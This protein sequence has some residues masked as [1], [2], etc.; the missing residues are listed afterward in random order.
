MPIRL[1]QLEF[2]HNK[3]A[4]GASSSSG[5]DT[6]LCLKVTLRDIDPKLLITSDIQAALPNL[7]RTYPELLQ[8]MSHFR[9]G[10]P[11]SQKEIQE[12]RICVAYYGKGP[13]RAVLRSVI[14][15]ASPIL[16]VSPEVAAYARA[17]LLD[18]SA[19][20]PR[21]LAKSEGHDATV[22]DAKTSGLTSS[23]DFRSSAASSQP[24]GCSSSTDTGFSAASSQP[25]SCSSS[26]IDICSSAASSSSPQ[27]SHSPRYQPVASE[28][29]HN[30]AN[31]ARLQTHA[32]YDKP[33]VTYPL[34]GARR[35]ISQILASIAA[36]AHLLSGSTVPRSVVFQDS[37]GYTRTVGSEFNKNAVTLCKHL[38]NLTPDEREIF[39]F[40]HATDLAECLVWMSYLGQKDFHLDNIMYD[41]KLNRLF[42]IDFD[43]CYTPK[44]D[45][46]NYSLGKNYSQD[47]KTDFKTVSLRDLRSPLNPADRYT[48]N[49]FYRQP[50]VHSAEKSPL[51]SIEKFQQLPGLESLV[52]SETFKQ[53]YYSSL[54]A[55][56]SLEA[57]HI[58]ACTSQIA[59]P[60]LRQQV[61][62]DFSQ[63]SQH[64]REQLCRM[65]EFRD[66]Y[67]RDPTRFEARLRRLET[68]SQITVERWVSSQT[69]K[70]PMWIDVNNIEKLVLDLAEVQQQI[71]TNLKNLWSVRDYQF[72]AYKQAIR[73]YTG[74]IFYRLR[75]HRRAELEIKHIDALITCWR[76]GGAPADAAE[77]IKKLNEYRL[78]IIDACHKHIPSDS[79]H[80]TTDSA[81]L[82]Q[83]CEIQLAQRRLD[84]Y[85]EA[86]DFGFLL[87]R[88][89]FNAPD[90][91]I[92]QKIT[93]F[94]KRISSLQK[95][96]LEYY[97]DFMKLEIRQ[98]TWYLNNF[99]PRIT[100][101]SKALMTLI[102]N[103]IDQMRQQTILVATVE[104]LKQIDDKKLDADL[105]TI[106]SQLSMLKSTLEN[107]SQTSLLCQLDRIR[108][109][110]QQ[111]ENLGS[112]LNQRKMQVMSIANDK[113]LFAG[114][115]SQISNWYSTISAT[116]GEVSSFLRTHVNLEKY[117]EQLRMKFSEIDRPMQ[118]MLENTT[119]PG[120]PEF[121][122]LLRVWAASK[123][124]P[125]LISNIICFAEQLIADIEAKLPT[126]G[127][128]AQPAILTLPDRQSLRNYQTQWARFCQSASLT[129]RALL[130]S[131]D[132]FCHDWHA[133]GLIEDATFISLNKRIVV[134][135][136]HCET[137]Q[138]LV[139]TLKPT[140]EANLRL[141]GE[142]YPRTR[143][144]RN[145][146]SLPG[147][148]PG[149]VNAQMNL[150]QLWHEDKLSAI[151]A[152]AGID[153]IGRYA[154]TQKP[155]GIVSQAYSTLFGSP[156]RSEDTQ[157]FYA[158]F[159]GRP[160]ETWTPPGPPSP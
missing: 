29:L 6:A 74:S 44:T 40:H 2:T 13:I 135:I 56:A 48:E 14:D 132:K 7:I 62:E 47:F 160:G 73:T 121:G 19:L 125:E 1:D 8:Q 22:S 67:R 155:K 39:L 151:E 108:I 159:T 82:M 113:L 99:I 66:Y 86:V 18:E 20:K 118:F 85:C 71:N 103:I 145:G 70:T 87:I 27:P 98:D 15:S 143:D 33:V 53:A 16:M 77:D 124:K 58:A 80:S 134:L 35:R 154:A 41:K 123:G 45:K 130:R 38:I 127:P 42:I 43:R 140:A 69:A 138:S 104:D 83:L 3:A 5:A 120:W 92:I 79:H 89:C 109:Q 57:S 101:Q 31:Q 30:S 128:S 95:L 23:T 17:L 122:R 78:R 81:P 46:Y 84:N 32:T 150:Y 26:S 50:E 153:A 91:D 106:E 114:E 131:L 54:Y 129:N 147:Q 107:L 116:W 9:V 28:R 24:S 112:I 55:C 10:L 100:A 94:S 102:D 60:T 49:W 110:R 115:F 148:R 12:G 11:K 117:Y 152:W 68:M 75:L 146:L 61:I 88:Q 105:R 158:S 144:W 64:L 139:D 52:K 136:A 141:F 142:A 4:G 119:A 157:A 72:D 96:W 63:R 76:E 37:N 34:I 149:Y 97:D 133:L 59:N 156:L 93:Y 21:K 65:P 36:L 25:S 90:I 111:I 51:H 137:F 126:V